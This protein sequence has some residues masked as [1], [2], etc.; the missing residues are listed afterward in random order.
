MKRFLSV[1]L[2]VALLSVLFCGCGKNEKR[3][4]YNVDLSKYVTLKDYKGVKVDTSTDEFKE[5]LKNEISSDV[6]QNNFYVKKTEGTVADGDTANIDYVGKK[7][8]V[9]FEGGTAQG[10][11]LTIGSNN[12]ID[13][14]EEG[15]IGVN[16]GDTVDLN[17]TFPENYQSTELAGK[18]VVFTVTVNYVTTNEEMKPEDY[19][20]ELGFKTVIEYNADVKKR[21]VKSYLLDKITSKAKISEYPED[22]QNTLCDLSVELANAQYQS[23]YGMTLEQVL[24]SYY[25][26]TLDDYK[27]QMKKEQLPE[28]MNSQ[29]PL[30]YIFDKENLELDK[31]TYK[32]Y[33]ENNK[34][35]A[36][37]QA[38]QVAVEDFL[39]KNAKI[40]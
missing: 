31:D 10:Y 28:L 1:V 20:K 8:G 37:F 21:A 5:L 40:K 3:N 13:G 4:L 16:I 27:K 12:F 32:K 39:Y 7:D 2:S 30:Y 17:L 22:D 9:A 25:N 33:E 29:M 18:A 35:V 14:F 38:V 15:L 11:D 19:Y 34:T 24:T 26:M 6:S 23:Q 36:E